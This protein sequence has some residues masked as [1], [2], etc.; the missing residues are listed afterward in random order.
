[1]VVVVPTAS[2]ISVTATR[3]APDGP[4]ATTGSEAFLRLRFGKRMS[5]SGPIDFDTS[6]GSHVTEAVIDD[7]GNVRPASFGPGHGG[8]VVIP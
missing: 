8:M 2:G 5:G 3:L 4:V 7:L 6:A 1:V